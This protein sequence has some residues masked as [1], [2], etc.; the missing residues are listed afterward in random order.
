[1]ASTG[2]G[3]PSSGP[4]EVAR[5]EK[6]REHGPG[7]SERT[8]GLGRSE[9]GVDGERFGPVTLTRH[10]KRDGRALILYTYDRRGRT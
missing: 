8:G 6:D 5:G 1:M 3:P 2:E 9:T 4:P 10:I 7:A